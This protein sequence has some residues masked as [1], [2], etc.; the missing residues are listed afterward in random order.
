MS[1]KYCGDTIR[2]TVDHVYTG[3]T[4]GGG[5]E[6][7]PAQ[8]GAAPAAVSAPAPEAAFR[9][10]APVPNPFRTGSVISFALEAAGEATVAVYD[11]TGRHVRDLARG[12]FG[13]G[14]HS[15]SWDGRRA[16]GRTV[17]GGVYFVRLET[18]EDARTAKVVYLGR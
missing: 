14:S 13:E 5:V 3:E 17:T 12:T 11:V 6:I 1:R 7:W 4:S 16:D 8:C 15:L 10:A 9:L 2:A 18:G